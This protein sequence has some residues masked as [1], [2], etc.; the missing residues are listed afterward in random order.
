MDVRAGLCQEWANP[1]TIHSATIPY[2]VTHNGLSM[3]VYLSPCD[4]LHTHWVQATPWFLPGGDE[5][6]DDGDDGGPEDAPVDPGGL[7]ASQDSEPPFV[8]GGPVPE[9][10][11]LPCLLDDG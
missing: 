8:D 6:G 11:R 1:T 2:T 9:L 5:P 7:G 3:V 4:C 10:F